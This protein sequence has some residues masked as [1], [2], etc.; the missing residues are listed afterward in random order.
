MDKIVIVSHGSMKKDSN[1]LEKISDLLAKKLKIKRENLKHAYLQHASPS[2][3][4]TIR[5]CLDEGAKKI[6]VF[7]FFLSSGKH[8][9]HDIPSILSKFNKQNADYEIVYTSP[10]GIHDKLVEIIV[11]RINESLNYKNEKS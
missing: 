4:D 6:I 10:L 5:Q 7:P 2:I 3:E 9:V 8:V 11:D 1:N